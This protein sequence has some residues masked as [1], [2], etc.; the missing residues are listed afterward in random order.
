MPQQF[1]VGIKSAI[2]DNDKLLLLKCYDEARNIF[3]W[4]LPG[5]RM[6]EGEAIMDTIKRELQEE[7]PGVCNVAIK[8]LVGAYKS[9]KILEDG[10]G[11]MMLIYKV[12]AQIPAACLLS[13]EHCDYRWATLKELNTLSDE[14]E[15][16][17][18]FKA[19]L[20]EAFL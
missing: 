12:N 18:A 2:V 20:C 3:L 5:G 1:H 17:D 8:K 13:D 10:S 14:A 19:V 15:L 6:E 11:I 4:D 16:T 9:P 7:L